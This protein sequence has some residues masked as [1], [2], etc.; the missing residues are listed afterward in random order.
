MLGGKLQV[1]R[2]GDDDER[3]VIDVLRLMDVPEVGLTTYSTVGLSDTP[4]TSTK[5][6]RSIRVELLGICDSAMQKFANILSTAAFSILKSKWP[7]FPGNVFPNVVTMYGVSKTMHHL[8]LAPPVPW[9][10]ELGSRVIGRRTVHWLGVYPISDAEYRHAMDFGSDALDELLA[11][12]KVQ[13]AD[14]GRRSLV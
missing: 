12:H 10:K 8:F 5:A 6:L 7:V 11:K 4:V 3:T 1:T 9:D 13:Y 2:F 14:L